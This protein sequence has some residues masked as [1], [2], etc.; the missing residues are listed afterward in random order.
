M[1]NKGALYS[2][3]QGALHSKGQYIIFIDSDDLVLRNGIYN[4]YN[5]IKK[6]NLSML[7][8]NSIS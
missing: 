6:Y 5:Y 4:S 1:K 2:R 8:Y 3:S 7:Q